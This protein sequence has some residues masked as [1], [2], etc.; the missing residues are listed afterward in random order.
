MGAVVVPLPVVHVRASSERADALLNEEEKQRRHARAQ[1]WRAY[2]RATRRDGDRVEREPPET[3][4]DDES[5]D[6]AEENAHALSTESL[7]RGG[8]QG[9]LARANGRAWTAED[10]AAVDAWSSYALRAL[11]D[12]LTLRAAIARANQEVD[13]DRG[14]HASLR[15]AAP[16][17]APV[18]EP[19]LPDIARGAE[20]LAILRA[21]GEAPRPREVIARCATM[22]Q[23]KA[24]AVLAQMRAAGAI[25]EREG[26]LYEP[27]AIARIAAAPRREDAFV[28]T[29]ISNAERGGARADCERAVDPSEEKGAA[30]REGTPSESG[31][32]GEGGDRAS[33]ASRPNAVLSKENTKEQAMG[34][35][36]AVR[37]GRGEGLARI[38]ALLTERGPLSH[39]EIADVVGISVANANV[40]CRRLLEKGAVKKRIDG[41]WQATGVALPA[42]ATAPVAAKTGRTTPGIGRERVL[43]AL[44]EKGSLSGNEIAAAVGRARSPVYIALGELRDLGLVEQTVDRKWRATGA[45][46]AAPAS[47]KA[48][49][50]VKIAP[51]AARTA[52]RPPPAP[53]GRGGG[54]DD[55][56][57]ADLR[58]RREEIV[59]EWEQLAGAHAAR[60][61]KIDAAIAALGA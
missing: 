12:G 51:A 19:S 16:A 32:D 52:R 28:P 43:E 54:Q 30:A 18:D 56:L 33:S 58:A 8:E 47:S 48:A 53:V 17:G 15:R 38:V 13:V 25:V 34:E 44:A 5:E 14:E 42:K 7:I 4:Q 55:R 20:V 3:E 27:G 41:R 23:A 60:L 26:R 35:A 1:A 59:A 22:R 24:Y 2:E 29:G 45:P 50:A 39:G 9:S 10:D 21:S 46:G 40:T 37:A 49:R 57:I 11:R 6:G 31:P 61:A 36:S